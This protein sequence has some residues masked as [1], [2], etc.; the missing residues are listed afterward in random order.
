M[1][2]EYLAT[3]G[4][5]LISDNADTYTVSAIDEPDSIAE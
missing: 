2:D 4:S 1:N 5:I 3:V